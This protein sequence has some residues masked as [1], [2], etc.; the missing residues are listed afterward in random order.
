MS[1][2]TDQILRRIQRRG[3]GAVFIPKDFLDLGGRAAVDQSLSRLARRGVIR[4]V[5]RGIYDYPQVSP[6]LGVLS[7][8]PDVVARAAARRTDSRLQVSGAQ[9]ANALGVST[10][11]PARLTYLTDGASRHLQVGGQTITFRHAAPRRLVGA[12]T[13]TGLVLQALRYLGR[14]GV[15]QR[16]V[17]TIAGRLSAD[18]ARALQQAASQVADWMRPVIDEIVAAA[19]SSRAA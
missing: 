11:V 8:R 13:T 2:I 5:G 4:R 9:A 17:R 7:P 1:T 19:P 14:D 3:R 6:R 15:D 10:Q 18:D 16:A 12:G